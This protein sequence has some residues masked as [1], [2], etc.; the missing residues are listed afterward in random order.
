MTVEKNA[1]AIEE[2]KREKTAL[3]SANTKLEN[4]V[5]SLEYQMKRLV[6]KGNVLITLYH[7][8]QGWS[9]A[10]HKDFV[11]GMMGE[12]GQSVPV[13]TLS[14]GEYVVQETY[15]VHTEDYG[16][17]RWLK[18]RTGMDDPCTTPDQFAW[19]PVEPTLVDAEELYEQ[20]KVADPEVQVDDYTQ[21]VWDGMKEGE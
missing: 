5:E 7:N 15:E 18:I 4:R 6:G 20:L 3:K 12:F 8:Q 14:A 11:I 16:K 13:W 17:V 19:L 1:Q 2:L 10:P 9:S 21:S